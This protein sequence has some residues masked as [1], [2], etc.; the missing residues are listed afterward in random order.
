MNTFH[1]MHF[2]GKHWCSNMLVVCAWDLAFFV[3]GRKERLNKQAVWWAAL[4][5]CFIVLG[6]VL[7]LHC[8]LS[9][10][11]AGPVNFRLS[12]IACEQESCRMLQW[13]LW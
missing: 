3:D 2:Y 12:T 4:L 13:K 5:V 6:L 9:L 7:L 8:C 10:G 1:S 11:N